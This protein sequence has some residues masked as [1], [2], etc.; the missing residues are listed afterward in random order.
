MTAPPMPRRRTTTYGAP[1][2]SV[3][4]HGARATFNRRRM[5]N[6][7][8]SLLL[9]LPSLIALGIFVY[10]FIGWNVRV[11]FTSW[12]GLTPVYDF[13]LGN[14][15][16]L[17]VDE[18]WALD[19]RNVLIFTSVFVVG[20]VALG[21][22][23]ALLLEKVGRGSSVYRAVFLFPM[24]ISFIATAIVWRW[25]LDNGSGAD[26]TGINKLLAGVG[27]DFLQSDWHRSEGGWAIAAVALPAGWALSGYVMALFLAGMRNIPDAAREAARVDG[28]TELQVFWYVTRPL[29]RTATVSVVVIL[30]HIWLKTFDLLYALDQRSLKIDT[31]SL[32]MWFTTFDGGF[33]NRGATIATVLLIGVAL[34]VGPYIRNAVR[35]S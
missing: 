28:A 18:R 10:G 4:P 29:L 22:T 17:F 15:V 5:P 19:V 16:D 8:P 6:W 33:Y 12:R 3:T 13:V 34:V 2:R 30:L 25:L 7:L 24:A 32:Y 11:S 1:N 9:V 27:L 23:M 20:A 26:T 31:P 35:R 14:Y 21:F